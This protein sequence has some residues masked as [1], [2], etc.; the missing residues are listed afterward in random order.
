MS[1][2]RKPGCCEGFRISR[3]KGVLKRERCR[4]RKGLKRVDLVWGGY[5]ESLRRFYRKFLCLRCRSELR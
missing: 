4:G 1:G 2:Y 3:K 5:G